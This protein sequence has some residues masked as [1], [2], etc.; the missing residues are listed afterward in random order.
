MSWK[1]LLKNALLA[2]V[3]VSAGLIVWQQ[4]RFGASGAEAAAAPP[5]SSAS[6][7][8]AEPATPAGAKE[9]KVRVYYFYTSV[10]CP[11]CR[12]IEAL[13]EEALKSAFADALAAGRVEWLPTNVQLPQNR[14]FV[15]DFELFTKSV[16]IVRIRNGEQA[17]WKNLEKVWELVQDKKTFSRYIEG[18]I[19]AYMKKL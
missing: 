18:E 16:V 12:Q 9:S 19:R 5:A 13:T 15:R 1:P 6:R 10:R 2:Y 4:L 17:E 7:S 3:A 14:H 11:T 8:R